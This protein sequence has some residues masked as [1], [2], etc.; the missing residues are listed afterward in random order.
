MTAIPRYIRERLERGIRERRDS[1][2]T[3]DEIVTWLGS[4]EIVGY[5][6]TSGKT[7]VL[8]ESVFGLSPEQAVATLRANAGWRDYLRITDAPG[9]A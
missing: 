2:Q 6:P 8:L 9:A 5:S 7:V 1:G 3:L 4:P